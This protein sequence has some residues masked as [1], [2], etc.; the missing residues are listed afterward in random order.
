MEIIEIGAVRLDTD[1][2]ALEDVF[3]SFVRP[4]FGPI[5]SEFRKQ[6]TSIRQENVDQAEPFTLCSWESYDLN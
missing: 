3:S 4:V 2:L 6:P 1:S 5:L